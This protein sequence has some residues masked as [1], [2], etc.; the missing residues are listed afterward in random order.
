MGRRYGMGV[1][2]QRFGS[3]CIYT[4]GGLS[5]GIIKKLDFSAWLLIRV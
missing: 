2:F 1:G 3:V 4:Y 5:W